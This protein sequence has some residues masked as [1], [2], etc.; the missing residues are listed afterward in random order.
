MGTREREPSNKRRRSLATNTDEGE[1]SEGNS[2]PFVIDNLYENTSTLHP[3]VLH[4]R[5]KRFLGDV[6]LGSDT[7]STGSK[8]DSVTTVHVPNTGPM[9]GLLDD[10]PVPV[11]LSKSSN[12]NRKYAHTL[13][14]M[15]VDGTWV[16]V[17]SAKANAMVAALLDSGRLDAH[18]PKYTRYN[19]E[20]KL[21]GSSR[22]DFELID[23]EKG[24]RVLAEV[25]SVTMREA[26]GSVA[27]FP[28]TKSE[29]AQ[30]HC[31]ELVEWKE[32][33]DDVDCAMMIYV[34]QRGDCAAFLPCKEKDPV[35]YELVKDA[36]QSDK[37]RVLVLQV[38][39][40]EAEGDEDGPRVVYRGVL[41]MSK[42]E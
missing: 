1:T 21:G 41:P 38:D 36:V 32:K 37:L 11:C 14:W 10:L 6:T 7:P 2:A 26:E 31:R 8:D 25:K 19:R 15:K 33:R 3:A 35:Y 28:D 34:V 12:K 27:V 9:T 39:L 20:V 17:H 23:E 30:K 42:F 16:G 18:L 5:Y 29:R 40:D 24:G 4:A 13:E 22:I